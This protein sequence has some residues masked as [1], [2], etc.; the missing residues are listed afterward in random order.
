[1]LVY[2]Y[3]IQLLWK[4]PNCGKI[5][6]EQLFCMLTNVVKINIMELTLFNKR[7][8][9]MEEVEKTITELLE[10]IRQDLDNHPKKKKISKQIDY[11]EEVFSQIVNYIYAEQDNMSDL[12]SKIKGE[13]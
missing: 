4:N 11:V 3:F 6:D 7:E 10:G 1:M 5:T 8:M 13:E 12:I 9:T 2:K